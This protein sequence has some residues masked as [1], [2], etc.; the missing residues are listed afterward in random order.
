MIVSTDLIPSNRLIN[1]LKPGTINQIHT[2][3]IAYKQMENI[4]AYL[5]ACVQ[6]GLKQADC[7][8]TIDLYEG[9]DINLV[10]IIVSLRSI[11]YPFFSLT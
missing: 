1:K 11:S 5:K 8:N 7:F 2:S 3:S 6:L 10:S 9:K 4:A